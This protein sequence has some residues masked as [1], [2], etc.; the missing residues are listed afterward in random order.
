[1]DRMIKVIMN[2]HHD[3]IKCSA[4]GPKIESGEVT[5]IFFPLKMSLSAG[6][7]IEL[8]DII[9]SK[10]MVSVSCFGKDIFVLEPQ[11]E[12]GR[13]LLASLFKK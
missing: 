3:Q 9:Q 7:S 13:I 1:M 12:A 8:A 2:G 10:S 11:N 4:L 5:Q 6:K